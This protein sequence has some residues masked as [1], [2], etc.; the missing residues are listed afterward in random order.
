LCISGPG[1][2]RGYLNRPE[3]T[4]E[5]FM[6][7]PFIT[8]ERMYKTGDLARW[9]SDGSIEFLGRVDN[10]VKIR[11][12]RIELAEIENILLRYEDIVSTLVLA[13]EGKDGEKQIVAYYVSENEIEILDLRGNLGKKLPDY[14]IPDYFIHLDSL[15]LTPNGKIDRKALPGPDGNINTGIEYVAPRNKTEEKLVEIWG[16]ILGI[17]HIGVFDNFFILG[18]HSLKATRVVSRISKDL[19]VEIKLKDIFENP[20]I[21]SISPLISKSDKIRYRQIEPI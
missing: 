13:K 8:G 6:E 14:M 20:T 12:F 11:G 18:G 16:D 1:L 4:S 10:Q 21:D 2:A 3:L 17:D 19:N 7:N 5:K 9:G 15:P